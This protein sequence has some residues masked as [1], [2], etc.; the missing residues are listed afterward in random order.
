ASPT[1]AALGVAARLGAGL[2]GDVIVIRLLD[3]FDSRRVLRA[4]VPVA[5]LLFPSFLLVPGVVPKLMMLAAL[6]LA[7]APWYPILQAELYGSLPGNSGLAVSLTSAA[8]LAGG[9]G[10]LVVGLLAQHLGIG[11]AMAS[12][13][14]APLLMLGGP[15]GNR[16]AAGGS[17]STRIGRRD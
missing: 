2:A 4:S 5:L 6:T 13:C 10:P 15:A 1:V 17:A 16:L 8:S 9:L 12:L 14:V 3:R 11:W 7:T